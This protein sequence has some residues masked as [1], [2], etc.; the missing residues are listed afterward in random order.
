MENKLESITSN[1]FYQ[2]VD[3]KLFLETA[4]YIE[5][6]NI[7][8]KPSTKFDVIINNKSYPPKDFLRVAAKLKGYK[9]LEVGF[10]GGQANKPFKD[11][12]FEIVQKL[13]S[14]KNEFAKWLL[15][16][17]ANSYKDYYGNSTEEIII[18]LD[19]ID[20]FFEIDIFKLR[21]NDYLKL[22]S[23]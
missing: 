5:S 3:D 11:L 22:K 18:K 4:E 17:G 10:T 2:L 19:E 14:L 7:E 23:L 15:K 20:S 6:N 9:I 1:K 21:N 13:K 8:L 12:K 16:N